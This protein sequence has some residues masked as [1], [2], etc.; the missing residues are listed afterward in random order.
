M[1]RFAGNILCLAA[2]SLLLCGCKDSKSKDDGSITYHKNIAPIIARNCATCHIPGESAPFALLTFDDVKKRDKQIAKVTQS[3]YMPPWLPEPGHGEFEGER[4]LSEADIKL[5]QD[6]VAAGSPEGK[7]TGPAQA[8]APPTTQP[9]PSWRLGKPDMVAQLPQ[10]Y[11]L[12]EKVPNVP[13][14]YRNFVIPLPVDKPRW[15]RA[16]ELHAGNKQVVHHAFIMFDVS[17][18]ARRKDAEDPTFGYPGMDAGE[19]VG[20]PGGQF[21][22]WQPGKT[23]SL[24]SDS[25]SWRLPRGTDMVLQFHM[26]PGGK[27][28]PVQPSVAFYFTDKPPTEFPYVLVL[29]STAMDIPPGEKSYVI[30]SSYT[31]PVDADLTG[32]LPHAHYLG[33]ELAGSATLPDGTTK[34]LLLIKN[35]DFNWQGDYRYAKPIFLPR[36]TKVSMRFTYDNSADN[37]RNPNNPPKPVRYG[38]NSTDEMGELWLQLTPKT[39]QDTMTLAQD[40]V[41]NYGINDSIARCLNI[42]RHS[43]ND[44]ATRT[45][46]GGFLVKTG[47]VEEGIKELRRAIEQNPS[48]ARAHFNLG[49]AL[50]SK[51]EPRE[52]VQEFYTV[53]KL[54]PENYRTHNNLGMFWMAQGRL[55]LASRHLHNAVRINP[56]DL[57]SN[58]N[59]AK[60]FITQRAWGQAKLQVQAVLEIDPDNATAKEVMKV[61]QREIDKE[62]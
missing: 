14:D 38:L 52:A 10:P 41:Q 34:P 37:V 25:R 21:L 56:N 4:R 12:P 2:A 62:R 33:R 6:W 53:L 39:L 51:N 36:G 60:L 44:A 43:P 57:T 35:W 5:I 24:G 61:V 49:N 40:Y 31:L 13:D 17:G 1:S 3:R 58:I 50:M 11:I 27:P 23:P 26:Q 19:D 54:D 42:L 55:D 46:L 9:G 30:E 8:S 45:E 48:L 32:I 20:S 22:S 18:S 7:P 15:V 59:L 29:R 47:K 28:E 16:V